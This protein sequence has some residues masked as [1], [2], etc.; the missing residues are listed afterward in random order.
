MKVI[1]IIEDHLEIREN[2]AELL[3]LHGYG[4]LEAE[5]G[6]EGIKTAIEKLPDLLICDILMPVMDGLEVLRELRNDDRIAHIPLIF[7]TARAEKTDVL[8][9]MSSGAFSY[10]MK[11]FTEEQLMNTIDSGLRSAGITSNPQE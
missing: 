8:L 1:L 4:V 5:N 11:P 3:T 7:L 2:L 10:I 9:G 6:K